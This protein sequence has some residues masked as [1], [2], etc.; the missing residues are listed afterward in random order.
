FDLSFIGEDG[1]EH[2]PFMVH[3]ALLGSLE[4]FMGV[5][6]EHYGGAFPVWLAPVQSVIIPITDGH[7][8]YANRV[9]EELQSAGLR[10]EVDERSERMNLKIREAQLQ[11]VPYMLVVGDNEVSG[12][13]LSVRLRSGDDLGAKPVATVK[14][15]ILRDVEAK[16]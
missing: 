9:A 12:Q 4:R 6:I 14:E 13:S 5:L 2:R 15:M 10:V 11:K 7:L 8:D 1:R 16:A 3:R